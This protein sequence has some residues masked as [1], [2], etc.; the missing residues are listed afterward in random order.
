MTP[1]GALASET[2]VLLLTS[3]GVTAIASTGLLGEARSRSISTY[4][5][6]AW[7]GLLLLIFVGA[8]S[9]AGFIG[10]TSAAI[11]L[12]AALSSSCII[13]ERGKFLHDAVL[14][15]LVAS[16][17]LVAQSRDLIRLFVYWELMSVS[18][19]VL[20]VFHWHRENLESAL[21]YVMMC[22]VG[23][24]LALVGIG[25]TVAE[26]G[27]TSIEA[28]ARA[29]PLAKALMAVGFGVEAAIFPLHFWLPD[30]HMA[31]PSTAS[32][33][34][35]GIAIETGAYVA[36][37]VALLDAHVAKA[38]ALAALIGAFIGNL[39]AIRQDD[40]K[41]MLAYSSVAHVSYIVLGLVAGAALAKTYAQLHIMAHG[42]LK[43]AAFLLSGLFIALW[44][45]RS[46][47]VLAGKLERTIALKF[48]IVALGLG[49]TGVPPFLTFWSEAFTFIGLVTTNF[50][51]ATMA[52]GMAIAILISAA[53]YFRLFYSLSVGKGPVLHDGS[54]ES[55][56]N[57][58]ERPELGASETVALVAILALIIVAIALSAFPRTLIDYFNLGQMMLPPA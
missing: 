33:L 56:G 39:A 22:G 44:G 15:A 19:L 16:A 53:F 8:R 25:M 47:S 24:L 7:T 9:P 29:S 2:S 27:S 35:S 51:A 3:A 17:Y 34:L 14:L 38:F 18:I 20:T 4:L 32:A 31:A 58:E 11:G 49:L 42:L 5:L 55:G 26:A 28:V 54:G 48:S 40:M 52:V 1:L 21:K 13:R 57:S 12:A 37:S 46:L 41:R 45:T 36:A 10:A 50:F 43:G 23:S 30:V 6:T